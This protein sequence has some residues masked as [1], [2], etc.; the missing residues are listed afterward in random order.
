MISLLFTAAIALSI[1]K[2][3]PTDQNSP[4]GQL[5]HAARLGDFTAVRRCFLDHATATLCLDSALDAAAAHGHMGI[6]EFLVTFGASDLESALLSAAARDHVKIVSYLVSK[7]RANPATNTQEAQVLA[8]NMG[9][10]NCDWLL[11]AHHQLN[12]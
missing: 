5:V 4:S 8:S 7:E 11:T 6:V 1:G 2:V 10:I 9:S 3:F 12:G